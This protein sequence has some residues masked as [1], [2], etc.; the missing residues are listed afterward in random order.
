MEGLRIPSLAIFV[1]LLARFGSGTLW[2]FT[3]LS[4]RDCYRIVRGQRRGPLAA[5]RSKDMVF[6]T[7]DSHRLSHVLELMR[8]VQSFE[9]GGGPTNDAR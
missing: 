8:Q 1:F 5:E 4:M 6:A 3:E 9:A 7:T 2:Q